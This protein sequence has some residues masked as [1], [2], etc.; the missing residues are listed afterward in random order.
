[1]DCSGPILRPASSRLNHSTLHLCKG[2]ILLSS[3]VCGRLVS[4]LKSKRFFGR[5]FVSVFWLAIKLSNGMA[6]LLWAVVFVD[7]QNKDTKHILF[8]CVLAKFSWSC[9]QSWLNVNW[10]PNNFNELFPLL[11]NLN[12]QSLQ[13]FWIAFGA[14][15]WSLWTVQNKFTIKLNFPRKPA[16]YLLKLIALLQL[17]KPLAKEEDAGAIDE[18]IIKIRNTASTLPI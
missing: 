6:R 4:L 11:R 3:R 1:M 14:Q 8:Y 12:G 13:F 2:T 10:D 9:V 18:L 5:P 16:N 15:C 7:G 17:W